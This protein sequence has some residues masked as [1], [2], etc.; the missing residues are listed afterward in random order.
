MISTFLAKCGISTYTNYLSEALIK[1]GIGI[2]VLAEEPFPNESAADKDLKTTVP[3]FYCWKRTE[4]YHRLIKEAVNYD[5]IHIQHQFG[6][7]NNEYAWLEL[8]RSIKI[9]KVV[10]IH[11][12][13][14]PNEKMLTYF[15]ETFV[16]VK[17]LIVHTPSC[18]SILQSWNCPKE[19]I[20]LIPHGTKLI[21]VPTKAEARKKL[22]L[23]EDAE[24]ILSW[25]FI[26]ESKGIKELV[27]ILAEIKK[28]HPKAMFIHAGG[29]HPIIE[30]SPYVASIL[31][32]AVKLGLSPK[33]LI[34]TKWIPED[35][36]PTWFGSAD[37][38]V[39]NYM[40]GSASAS[41]AAHRAMASHRPLVGTDDPC[42]EDIPKFTVP[43]F[44][45]TDLYQGIIKVLEDKTLQ[46][47]LVKQAEAATLETS[48][49]NIARRHKKV[50]EKL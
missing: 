28:T 26:W 45:S 37:L 24:I 14:P 42:I 46:E 1:Q 16:N 36:V 49:S 15:N 20:E 18:Y 47:T 13:V 30:K 7:F 44:S 2:T 35:D 19:K 11:D 27:E 29:V 34:I 25:G 50:Y 38:I 5:L 3:Y 43:R 40:R 32:S 41:G 23:P 17:K 31:K 22:N 6:L 9:P 21:D 39:L 12:I 8:L 10:T 4:M 48:W 33:D